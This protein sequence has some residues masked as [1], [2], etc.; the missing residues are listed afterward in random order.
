MNNPDFPA[1]ELLGVMALGPQPGAMG[2]EFSSNHTIRFDEAASGVI[3][4]ATEK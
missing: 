1:K 2:V 4:L 3:N